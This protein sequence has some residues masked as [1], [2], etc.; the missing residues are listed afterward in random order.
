VHAN[1]SDLFSLKQ[2]ECNLK[3]ENYTQVIRDALQIIK[4]D[5]SNSD[6]Y[7]LRAKGLY[8]MENYDQAVSHLQECLRLNPDH[9]GAAKEIKKVR[10]IVR[11]MKAAGDA[12]FVR[13]FEDAGKNYTEALEIDKDNKR[14]NA[15]LLASRAEARYRLGDLQHALEDGRASIKLAGDTAGPYLTLA[16]VCSS[17]EKYDEAIST[18]EHVLQHIDP[19]NSVAMDRLHD[20]Q[21]QQRKQKRTNYYELLGVMSVASTLEIRDA[22]KQKAMEWHPDKHPEADRQKAEQKFKQIQEAYEVLTDTFKKELYDK[23]Y[24]LDAINEQVQMK[25]AREKRQKQQHSGGGCGTNG[26]ECK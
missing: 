7:Y 19:N 16:E 15:K 11:L 24:D 13:N 9:T 3:L 4:A 12:A 6:A 5:P 2:I 21:F 18:L 20:A 10:Q 1:S 22:Y 25:Q 23:G 14:L 8:Y 26:C 17:M